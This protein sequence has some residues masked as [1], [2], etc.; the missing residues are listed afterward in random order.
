MLNWYWHLECL[1]MT[2]SKLSVKEVLAEEQRFRIQ[3]MYNMAFW[4]S[5]CCGRLTYS[6]GWALDYYQ[7][8]DVYFWKPYPMLV[9]E[10]MVVLNNLRTVYLRSLPLGSSNM[11][12]LSLLMSSM[13]VLMVSISLWILS[14]WKHKMNVTTHSLINL[15]QKLGCYTVLLGRQFLTFWRNVV[16][17]SQ[18]TDSVS[19]HV[20]VSVALNIF[21]FYAYVCLPEDG[22]TRAETCCSFCLVWWVSVDCCKMYCMGYHWSVW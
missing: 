9:Q 5:K 2:V 4:N 11:M 17:H 19:R 15:Q 8:E 16:L 12:L 3:R 21:P 1:L 14:T 20:L 13:V 7:L 10:I 22:N 6:I 18:S